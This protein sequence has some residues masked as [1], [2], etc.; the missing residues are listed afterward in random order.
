MKRI[1]ITAA[2]GTPA[3][4][5]VR[6]LRAA[7]EKMYLVGTDCDKYCLMRA[8]TDEKFLVPEANKE[9]Y[10]DILNQI[11]DENK[12]EF[13]HVQN[14]IEM[15]I[16]SENRDKL[17]IPVFLPSKKTVNI[18]LDKLESY[19]KWEIAGIKQP[20]TILIANENDLK[21]AFERLGSKIWIRDTTGAGGRGSLATSSFKVAKAWLDFREG[22]NKYTAAE[23]LEPQSVTWQSIWREGELI[24]AQARKRL[25]WELSRLAPSG[26]TGITGT[27]ITFSDEKLDKI[28]QEAI[29]AIDKK[30]H[31][32]FSVDLTYDKDGLPNPT[33]I[34]I[35]R[36]FTTHEF[37]T[38]A[39]LNMPYIVVKIAYNEK[40]P[41]IN[42]KLNPLPNNLAWVRGVDFVPIL[43]TTD[44]INSN[45]KL[46][47]ERRRKNGCN[48]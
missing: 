9:D 31:G 22:W 18:C 11:I 17:H 12:L 6:S 30:P 42:K 27:G 37:F 41:H 40:I 46:L 3:T 25:Y 2:G 48:K 47:E 32:I 21:V 23:C 45:V 26:I 1:M 7:P 44:E 4:N 35:G 33:E 16:I 24:V 28:A 36:F 29:F 39:G 8:E 13:L 34:N 5:F 10:I 19:K 20:K 38:K 15:K 14:D 43:T